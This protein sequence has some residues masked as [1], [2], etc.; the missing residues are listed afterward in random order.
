VLNV[1]SNR[2]S[3]SL[4]RNIRLL[5]L[6]SAQLDINYKLHALTFMAKTHPQTHTL[7]FMAKTHTKTHT[8][9]HPHTISCICY[10]LMIVDKQNKYGPRSLPLRWKV[11]YHWEERTDVANDITNCETRTF[12]Q[13]TFFETRKQI[14]YI[15]NWTKLGL[16]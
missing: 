12:G 7:T 3:E 1:R 6:T 15:C 2:R 16:T 5:P 8:H 4:R 13:K 9:T 10:S 14:K 11:N